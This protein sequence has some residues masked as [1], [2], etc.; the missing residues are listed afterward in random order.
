[1]QARDEERTGGYPCEEPFAAARRRPSL[2]RLNPGCSD[3][4]AA[5]PPLIGYHLPACH[6]PP[7][8]LLTPNNTSGAAELLTSYMPRWDRPPIRAPLPWRL[9]AVVPSPLIPELHPGA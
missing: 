8:P 1:M 9:L 5:G 3:R 7:V 2:Q 6:A 4:F